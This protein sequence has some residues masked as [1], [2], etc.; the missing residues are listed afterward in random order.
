MR[1]VQRMQRGKYSDFECERMTKSSP[2]HCPS[3]ERR[4]GPSHKAE[5][6]VLRGVWGLRRGP[7]LGGSPISISLV[8]FGPFP[9]FLP[10][11]PQAPRNPQ[12]AAPG[13]QNALGRLGEPPPVRSFFARFPAGG[14]FWEF[15]PRTFARA[16]LV[17]RCSSTGGAS[18]DGAG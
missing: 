13:P 3:Q 10:T 12:N 4:P 2:G 11:A 8:R 9:A 17:L 7:A 1:R 15:F 18:V 16:L 14:P 6:G 5:E